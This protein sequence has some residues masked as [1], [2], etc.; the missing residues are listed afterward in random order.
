MKP[1]NFKDGD[2]VRH[3]SRG[4]LGTVKITNEGHVMVT[5]D[6]STPLGHKSVGIYDYNWFEI[7][8]NALQQTPGA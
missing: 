4:E 6:N 3:T 1:E 7:Y 5:F 8:P 2:R